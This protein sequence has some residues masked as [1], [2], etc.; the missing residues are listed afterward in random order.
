MPQKKGICREFN[1]LTAT[2]GKDGRF[3]DDTN[4]WMFDCIPLA[5]KEVL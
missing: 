1:C 4:K 2:G 3:F 5:M